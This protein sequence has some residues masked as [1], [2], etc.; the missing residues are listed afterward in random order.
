MT[1]KESIEKSELAEYP[2]S[3]F[4]GEI[5]V[6]D[7]HER[8]KD[9]IRLLK[10]A[11]ILGFDTETKPSFSK[12]RNNRVALLQLSDARRAFLFRVNEIGLPDELIDILSDES[13][14]KVGVAIHDD[15]KG[16]KAIR[17]FRPGGFIE[18]Q[19]YVKDFGITSSGLRK[20]SAIILGFRISK[21]QQV[22]NWEANGLTDAQLQYAATDAWVC[23][24][25]YKKLA[26]H[27]PR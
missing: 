8:L 11:E 6:V 21:R 7:N 13:V 27:N 18:L 17:N 15:I 26:N 22:S 4:R 12:G 24:E 5:M 16:L 1:Y 2:V 25:I 3:G 10:N 20:L 23:Y 19:D 9:S 14:T